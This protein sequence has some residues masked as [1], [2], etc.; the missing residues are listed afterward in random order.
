MVTAAVVDDYP[1]MRELL[2]EFLRRAKFEVVGDAGTAAELLDSYAKWDPDVLILD[3]LL[4]DASGLE[5]T[6]KI[7]AADPKA[8]IVIISGL[9]GDAKLTKECL[10]AGA[11]AFLAKP[12]T[13]EE[14]IKVLKKI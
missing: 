6:K 8:K 12:F 4:P 14:L 11:K 10:A 5:V 1:V 2:R 3:I 13:S 9:E 7:V